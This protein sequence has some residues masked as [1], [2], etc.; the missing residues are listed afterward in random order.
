MILAKPPLL[1][2]TVVSDTCLRA[3]A[4]QW[5]GDHRRALE[6]WR[7]NPQLRAPHAIVRGEVLRAYAL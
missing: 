2:R 6:L 3:L 5:Y 7:L 1:T 4:H